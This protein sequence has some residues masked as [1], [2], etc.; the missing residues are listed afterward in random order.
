VI[1][2]APA[3]NEDDQASHRRANP[4]VAAMLAEARTDFGLASQSLAKKRR[5]LDPAYEF[6]LEPSLFST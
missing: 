1:F 4:S 6:Y 2:P 5:P 3:D